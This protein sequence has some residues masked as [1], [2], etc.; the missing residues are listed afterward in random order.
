MKNSITFAQ[1]AK[2]IQNK[3]KGR[4]DEISMNSMHKELADLEAQQE[5]LRQQ[6]NLTNPQEMHAAW[7]GPGGYVNQ[8]DNNLLAMG[9]LIKR[10][11]GTYS[12]RGLW[13]NIRANKGS[14]K[15]PTKQM[16]EQEKKIKQM[17]MGG[18]M[19]ADGGKLQIGRA[20]V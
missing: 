7:G 8:P 9:G 19:Y 11:D 1:Q 15:K 14:G 10:A 5:A 2:R 3:Y 4:T 12:Q 17:A 13:D 6:M 18:Y 20:H 16:L